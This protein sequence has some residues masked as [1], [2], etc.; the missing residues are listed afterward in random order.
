[1]NA[2]TEDV[3]LAWP[4]FALAAL[5]YA[6][7][8][9]PRWQSASASLTTFV[10]R[11]ALPASLFI[12]LA[13]RSQLPPVDPRL[14]IAFFG[15]CGIVFVVGRLVG[16]VL[17][18]DGVEQSVLALGG[19]FSNNLLLGLPL[20]TTLLGT[21][22]VPTVA[23]V[24]VFNSLTLWTL[25]TVSVEWARKGSLSVNGFTATLRAVVA[26]PIIIGILGG[27]AYSFTGRPLPDALDSPLRMLATTAGPLA[28]VALGM[29][30]AAYPVHDG[31][32]VSVSITVLKLLVQP[33]VVWGLAAALGLPPLETSAVVLLASIAVGA[34]VYLMAQEF[35]VL[36]GPVAAS[37]VLT[38][39][40]ASVTTPM[41]LTLVGHG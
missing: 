34:N 21:R 31:W 33:A 12:L 17:G 3:R 26:N 23:L 35:R 6:L 4:L 39:A 32:R 1:M 7:G 25:V 41:W 28:L 13:D 37:L 40:L 2:F 20:A 10:F 16:H 5:G 27:T 22:A 38:T 36:Q 29:G 9:R 14:L 24:L 15:G 8:R 30:L 11:L 19:I 18:L